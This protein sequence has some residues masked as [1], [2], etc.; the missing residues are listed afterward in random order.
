MNAYNSTKEVKAKKREDI[1]EWR[2]KNPEKLKEQKKRNYYKYQE[3]AK[4]RSAEWYYKNKDRSRNAAL[5]R[6]YGISLEDFDQLRKDQNYSCFLCN[7]HEEERKQSL[8]VDHNHNT[9]QA[10]RLL[11]TSCNVGIGMLKDS[12]DLLRKAAEYLENKGDYS[13]WQT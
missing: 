6:K 11:C 3:R 7:T 5:Q 2:K 9:G 12:P 8:V 10:R 1:K 13:S 4:Q